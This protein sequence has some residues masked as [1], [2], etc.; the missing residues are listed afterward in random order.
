MCAPSLRLFTPAPFAMDVSKPSDLAVLTG[1]YFE[2]GMAKPSAPRNRRWKY[3]RGNC[4]MESASTARWMSGWKEQWGSS[5]FLCVCASVCTREYEHTSICLR[6]SLCK[7]TCIC[8]RSACKYACM[9]YCVQ[10]VTYHTGSQ[11]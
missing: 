5:F 6:L 1:G 8:R 3:K 4:N 7:C 9:C 11:G 10:C 2:R